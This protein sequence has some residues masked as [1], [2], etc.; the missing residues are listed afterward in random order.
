LAKWGFLADNKIMSNSKLI[1]G[2]GEVGEIWGAALKESGL[3]YLQ[4]KNGEEAIKSSADFLLIDLRSPQQVSQAK[5]LGS[6][7]KIPVLTLVRDNPSK[8]ELLQIKETG[9]SNYVCESVPTEE[10][11]LRIH[12][13]IR[14]DE[15]GKAGESRSSKRVWFQQKV[16]FSIFDKK[17][18][19]W[20]TTLS[21]TGIFLR[22]ELSFPLYSTMRLS[23]AL[24]GDPEVFECDGVIVRQE[25]E[26]QMKGLG[27]MFQKL[28]GENIRR[29]ESFFEIY[30]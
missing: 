9:T 16:N 11:V 24:W 30:R 22:T 12:S 20:S 2:I 8:E 3:R 21:E 4:V 28:K 15:M 29:L 1:A 17:Y 13:M 14:S 27:V 6:S 10:I 18:S 26:S 23:F 7:S 25:V 5:A 19:A